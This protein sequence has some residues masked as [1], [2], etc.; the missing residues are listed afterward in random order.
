M[1]AWLTNM[2]LTESPI[3]TM[4]GMRALL[5]TGRYDDADYGFSEKPVAR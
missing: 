1:P 4:K 5:E 2:L 3:K